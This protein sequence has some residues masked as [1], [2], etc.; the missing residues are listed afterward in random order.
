MYPNDIRGIKEK[1]VLI[2]KEFK[3]VSNETKEVETTKYDN[4]Y[5]SLKDKRSIIK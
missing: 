3:E 5:W 1:I 4:D 2:I